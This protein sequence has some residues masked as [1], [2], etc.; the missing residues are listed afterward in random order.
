MESRGEREQVNR[1]MI[2]AALTGLMVPYVGTLAWTGTIRGEELRYEQQKEVSGRRRILL[3]RTG[4]S[5]Y[6]DMEEYLPGVLARQ[7]PVEYEPEALKAQ[8]IIARTYICRQMEAAGETGQ[9]GEIA[10]SAL[11]MDYVEADQLKRLWGSSRFPDY[12]KRLEDAVKATSG[13]V[14]TYENRCIDP[15]FCRASAGMTRKGDFTHPYLE[16]V[17]CPGDVE[18]EGFVQIATFSKN[19]FVSGINSIPQGEGGNRQ[20]DISQ[21]P[22]TIQIVSRDDSGYVD[23]IQIGN[24]GFTG[25]EVQYALGLQSACFTLETFEDQIRAV[26]KGIG[27]GYGMSQATANEKAKEGWKAED[28]LSYFYKNITFISE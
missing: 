8:A 25:E 9:S 1:R 22:D 3:D 17:D 23:Q 13:L 26:V 20:V 14:M 2:W 19:D 11:D 4:G 21:V 10:E 27:H 16:I 12:Y 5:Y 18:A 28:I 15:M 6:M 24:A 7:M